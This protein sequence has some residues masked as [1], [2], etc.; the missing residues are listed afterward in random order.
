MRRRLGSVFVVLML[1][2][3]GNLFVPAAAPAATAAPAGPTGVTTRAARSPQ[4][5]PSKGR[6]E[7]DRKTGPKPVIEVNLGGGVTMAFV[8]IRPGSFLAAGVHKV[9]I[10]KPF[11]LGKYEVTQEQW[12][13]VMGTN[14]S[15]CKGPKHPVDTVSWDDCQEFLRK[16][17]KKIAGGGFR[18]PKEAEWEYACWAGSSG[19]NEESLGAYAWTYGSPRNTTQPVGTKRPNAWG[20]YDMH[21]NVW[22]WC[23]DLWYR[24]YWPE[25][26][27]DPIGS[28][29]GKYRDMR[30]GSRTRYSFECKAT[31]RQAYPTTARGYDFGFRCARTVAVPSVPVPTTNPAKPGQVPSRHHA[32]I[33]L[34]PFVFPFLSLLKTPS[35]QTERCPDPYR[36]TPH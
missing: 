8:L 22:E 4:S 13:A 7:E 30:G 24:V 10:T 21:G 1:V 9:T 29:S 14:P 25:E 33:V 6:I 28:T 26:V 19:D 11:Y 35:V 12:K 18:L 32:S 16:L 36:T 27:I 17:N 2:F 3:Q 5:S 34:D 15:C 31:S 20:L 23:A